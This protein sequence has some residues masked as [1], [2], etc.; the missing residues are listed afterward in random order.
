MGGDLLPLLPKLF[1]SKVFLKSIKNDFWQEKWRISFM[2]CYN[3]CS[4][5]VWLGRRTVPLDRDST[6]C[7]L[8]GRYK[9]GRSCSN[10]NLLRP[11]VFYNWWGNICGV[12]SIWKARWKA[13]LP[14]SF[15][16]FSH[17]LTGKLI[18]VL[19]GIQFDFL[20]VVDA[21]KSHFWCFI[22]QSKN[23]VKVLKLKDTNF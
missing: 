21:F 1:L 15:C 20:L 13:M 11:R 17:N 12:K 2:L 6:R 8:A 23:V 10:S 16:S 9:L 14:G 7:Y 19:K 5:L 3:P 4:M 18:F 22:T